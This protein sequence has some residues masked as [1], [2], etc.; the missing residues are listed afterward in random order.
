MRSTQSASEQSSAGAS[1]L[2]LIDSHAHLTFP[3]LGDRVEE[4]LTSAAKTG[5]ETIITV[6]TNLQ[7]SRSAVGLAERHSPRVAAVAGVHPHE[8]EK[9]SEAD[10]VEML[11]L[12]DHPK[13]VGFGEMGL[14]YHYDFADRAVQRSV[15]ARQLELASSRHQ[16]LVI[17]CRE[18]LDDTIQLLA[19]HGYDHNPVVFHCFTGTAEEAS[20]VASHGWRISF[21]GI[22]TF[23]KSLGLQEIAKAYPTDK[24]MLETDSPYLSPEPVRNRRPNEPAH[25]AHTARFLA[26]LRGVP[27]ETLV[28]ETGRN[29][30]AFFNL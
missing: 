17:H 28:D 30:R 15:F 25:L 12:W 22:V 9:V 3:G 26:E 11:R 8:A 13:V 21:T 5:V 19:D 23:R 29:T 1:Q 7:D 2:S 20:L 24:L 6:G 14:D 18:A 4:V 10:L 27:Y 16:P